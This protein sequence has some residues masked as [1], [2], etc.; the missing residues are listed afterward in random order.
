MN[1]GLHTIKH[2]EEITPI[3]TSRWRWHAGQWVGPAVRPI[4]GPC[5]PHR[6]PPGQTGRHH[7]PPTGTGTARLQGS[8]VD[9]I[10]VFF[11]TNCHYG[12]SGQTNQPSAMTWSSPYLSIKDR[13]QS[14][15]ANLRRSLGS[16]L[17]L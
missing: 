14:I 4:R 7:G 8:L 12:D 15:R 13:Q 9:S 2:T 6:Q 17:A 1:R 5:S 10:T 16:G 3:I 11:Q